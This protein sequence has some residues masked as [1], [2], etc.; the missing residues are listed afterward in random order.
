MKVP[1]MMNS[2]MAALSPSVSHLSSSSNLVANGLAG[3]LSYLLG[4]CFWF[5]CFCSRLRETLLFFGFRYDSLDFGDKVCQPVFLF[6]SPG[7]LRWI[8]SLFAVDFCIQVQVPSFAISHALMVC[9]Y[10]H[11]KQI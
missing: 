8:F 10:M 5:T 3:V 4:V 11:D 6:W 9:I 2:I 1:V 7:G